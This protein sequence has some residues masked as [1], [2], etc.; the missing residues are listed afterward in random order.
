MSTHFTIYCETD[1]VMGPQVRRGAGGVGLL[2]STGEAYESALP[3][4][5]DTQG[6]WAHFLIEHEF[7]ELRLLREGQRS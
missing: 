3:E 2:T 5:P 6:S 4:P 1:D 7:C